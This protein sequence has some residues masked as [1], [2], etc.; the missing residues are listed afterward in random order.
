VVK[1]GTGRSAASTG[2][3]RDNVTTM[4]NARRKEEWY[5]IEAPLL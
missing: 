5:G 2:F 3:K 1:G 4:I